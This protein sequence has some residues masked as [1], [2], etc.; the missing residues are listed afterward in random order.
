MNS[1]TSLSPAKL[2]SIDETP[3]LML[4]TDVSDN[5]INVTVANPYDGI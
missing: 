5:F 3:S 2:N 4:E 1:P